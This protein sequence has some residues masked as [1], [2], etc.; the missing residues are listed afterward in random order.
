MNN[1]ACPIYRFLEIDTEG[2]GPCGRRVDREH[3]PHGGRQNIV[4]KA[5]D[6]AADVPEYR[7]D[8]LC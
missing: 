2:G 1:L 8:G 7:A 6:K 4:S 5:A 3:P